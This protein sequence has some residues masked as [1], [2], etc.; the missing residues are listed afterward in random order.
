[1]RL[2]TKVERKALRE[3]VRDGRRAQKRLDRDWCRRAAKRGAG[4]VATPEG[5]VTALQAAYSEGHPELYANSPFFEPL[6]GE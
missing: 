6:K 3:K 1:M 5:V 2:L 4:P